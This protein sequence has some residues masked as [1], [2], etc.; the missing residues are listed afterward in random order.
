LTVAT[1]SVVL[2]TVVLVTGGLAEP[3][4][5]EE[6]GW[7]EAPDSPTA[8]AP[9]GPM[10]T[11]GPNEGPLVV[12]GADVGTVTAE[13]PEVSG[14]SVVVLLDASLSD[15]PQAPIKATLANAKPVTSHRRVS[16]R[17]PGTRWYF[18]DGRNTAG[19]LSPG[20]NPGRAPGGPAAGW[21]NYRGGI[22]RL[23]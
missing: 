6:P 18:V 5:P 11:A 9:L 7:P 19:T 3:D 8:P 16:R 1:G 21:P 20:A 15:P 22:A 23:M 4:V 13:A 17:I 2:V 12:D 10:A 14:A